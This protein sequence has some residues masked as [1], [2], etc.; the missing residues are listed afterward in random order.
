[1]T[2]PEAASSARVINLPATAA[3]PI[4]AYV[5]VPLCAPDGRVIGSFCGMSRGMHDLGERDVRFMH[6]LA[7][8]VTAEIVANRAHAHERLRVAELI[9]SATLDIALQP[10]FDVHN[11]RCLGMEALARFPATYGATEDVFDSATSVGLGLALERLA[12]G[13]AITVLPLLM[14]QQYL[15]VN[16]TPLVAHQLAAAGE[17]RAELLPNLVLEITEHE[18]V[19]SYAELRRVL[20]PSRDQGLRLA[21]DDAGAGYASLKHVVELD[22]DIIKIDRSLVHGATTDRAR[23]SA[24]SAFIL[25]GLDIGALVVAEGVDNQQDLQTVIDLGVDG[26]QGFLLA[27][28][29]ENRAAV[30]QWQRG[31][32]SLARNFRAAKSDVIARPR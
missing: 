9:E 1:M 4:G 14:P 30:S 23:R 24:I 6:L 29:T 22:P 10:I 13:R 2:I 18:A 3:S 19:E 31:Q 27:P 7:E 17:A 28:P 11:G 25:L 16:L 20:Q 21:I 5:G 26:A 15:A 8:M 32:R 12:L